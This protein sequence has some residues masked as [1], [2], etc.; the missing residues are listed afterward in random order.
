MQG[1]V[2]LY[3]HENRLVRCHKKAFFMKKKPIEFGYMSCGGG[4]GVE[5]VYAL[6]GGWS[7]F[8]YA[9]GVVIFFKSS[10]KFL[11]QSPPPP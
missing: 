3:I 2:V 5:F 1:G 8:T 4:G 7:Y 9:K 6:K 10:I 11:H